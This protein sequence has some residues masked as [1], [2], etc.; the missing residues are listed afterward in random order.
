MAETAPNLQKMVAEFQQ[1]QVQYQQAAQQR[2]QLEM[3]KSEADAALGALDGL[4]DDAAVYRNVGSLLVKETKA[5]AQA[6][7]KEDQETIEVRLM[8]IGKQETSLR[9]QLQAA[10]QKL[11][12]AMPKA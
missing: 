11:Q 7:L 10:Q 4:A 1:M 3:M 5:S 9:D 2:S 12:A 6:R 8:R